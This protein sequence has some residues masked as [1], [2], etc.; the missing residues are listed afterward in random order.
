MKKQLQSATSLPLA[1]VDERR[2][3]MIKYSV[4]MG[5]RMVCIVAMLF[6]SGWWLVVCATGA[7]VLPYFA[8]IIA[9]V[10]MAPKQTIVERPS[11]IVLYQ[12]K[13]S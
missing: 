9:N 13:S 11:T 8:M 12:E 4:A 6:V 5:I 2:I 3:R 1:P 10:K 7:I